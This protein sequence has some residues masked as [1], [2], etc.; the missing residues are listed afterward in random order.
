RKSCS[1]CLHEQHRLRQNASSDSATITC[2][3]G[4]SET[5]VPV[6][7]QGETI[8]FL[9][10]GQVRLSTPT[11]E[12]FEKI[13]KQLTDWGADFDREELRETYFATEPVSPERYS[14]MISLL[15]TFANH[16]ELVAN[17]IVVQTENSEPPLIRKAKAFI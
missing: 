9:Q 15:Q 12:R 2:F 10:T 17:Q 3:A 11:P 1:V 8:G 14:S 7:H 16:L 4:L 13:A 5:L 6:R